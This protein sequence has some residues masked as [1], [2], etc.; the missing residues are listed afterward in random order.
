MARQTRDSLDQK[1]RDLSQLVSHLMRPHP[2]I[3]WLLL[4]NRIR[5]FYVH[6]MTIVKLPGYGYFRSFTSLKR[7]NAVWMAASADFE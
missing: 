3:Y 2:D 6:S 5:K 1:Y 7:P 4:N